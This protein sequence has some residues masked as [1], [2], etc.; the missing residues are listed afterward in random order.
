MMVS[1]KDSQSYSPT[2]H[3]KYNVRYEKHYVEENGMIGFE[4][5]L[6]YYTTRVSGKSA[7]PLAPAGPNGP[8]KFTYVADPDFKPKAIDNE[9]AP[10]EGQR[11]STVI[12]AVHMLDLLKAF[13]D[14]LLN[15]CLREHGMSVKSKKH[16]TKFLE[17]MNEASKN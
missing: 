4:D 1:V 13:P 14:S 17:K 5:L 2:R 12:M 10:P 6:H 8:M 7:P 9:F 11:Q 16:R 3:P 15:N